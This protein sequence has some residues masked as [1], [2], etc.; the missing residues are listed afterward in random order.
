MKPRNY[1]ALNPL[2]KKCHVHEEKEQITN[3][4]EIE[5]GIDDWIY[6]KQTEVDLECV[7]Y[8]RQ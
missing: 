1:T 5:D 7:E 3:T 6:D 4:Q 8:Y 2:L